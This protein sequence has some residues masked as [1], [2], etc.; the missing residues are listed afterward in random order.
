VASMVALM[1]HVG[2]PFH[3]AQPLL[4]H[5]NTIIII[6]LTRGLR[7][8]VQVP[9]YLLANILL[10]LLVQVPVLVPMVPVQVLVLVYLYLNE[11]M[12]PGKIYQ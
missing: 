12:C 3:L 6:S 4:S 7:V 11:M 9:V 2:A 5:I 1:V 8:H 10:V